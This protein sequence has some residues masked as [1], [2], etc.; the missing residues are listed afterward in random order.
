MYTVTLNPLLT[1]DLASLVTEMLAA[2]SGREFSSNTM[3]CN[4][5][6]FAEEN[7]SGTFHHLFTTG[8]STYNAN[9][10]QIVLHFIV[11]TSLVY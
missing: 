4:W 8:T 2:R 6:N 11:V 10:I 3:S 1:Q 7:Q 9:S 5:I